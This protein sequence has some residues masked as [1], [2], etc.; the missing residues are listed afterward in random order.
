MQDTQKNKVYKWESITVAPKDKTRVPFEQ[1]QSIVD[2]VWKQE[3]LEY[4]PQVM[5]KLHK[6]TYSASANRLHIKFG[7]KTYTWL[8]LHEIAHSITSDCSGLSNMHGAL[9]MGIY[10][11]LLKKYLH[12]DLLESAERFGLQIKEDAEPVFPVH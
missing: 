3:G 4:P 11:K 9:F 12:L 5:Q 7:E 10:L 1:I 8:I 6:K 2:Y